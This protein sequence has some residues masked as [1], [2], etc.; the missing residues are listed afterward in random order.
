MSW[1]LWLPTSYI[2][3]YHCLHPTLKS[4]AAYI[5]HQSLPLPMS[6]VGVYHCLRPMSESIAA[7][8]LPRSLRLPTIYKWHPK[9]PTIHGVFPCVHIAVAWT[10]W[11]LCLPTMIIWP[12]S[13]NTYWVP[14]VPLHIDNFLFP[15]LAL[16]CFL[17][18]FP[19]CALD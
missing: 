4:T 3:V 9:L 7:Y 17:P 12:S 18:L 5:L 10:K 16:A 6:F 2:R 14:T 1:A 11:S 8:I 19:C 13:S 15:S